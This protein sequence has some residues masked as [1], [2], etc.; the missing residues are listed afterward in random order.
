MNSFAD[1]R[2][3]DGHVKAI[4]ESGAPSFRFETSECTGSYTLECL[5]YKQVARKWDHLWIRYSTIQKKARKN[6]HSMQT[7]FYPLEPLDIPTTKDLAPEISP[8][9]RK[10]YRDTHLTNVNRM[11]LKSH[12]LQKYILHQSY[13]S[14]T[15]MSCRPD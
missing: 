9:E 10:L 12:Y 6:S 11:P 4:K 8:L 3:I 2:T 1:G 13:E 14:T 7:A 5:N 15:K